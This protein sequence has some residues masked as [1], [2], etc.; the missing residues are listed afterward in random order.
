MTTAITG[1]TYPVKDE[2]KALGGRWNAERKAWMVPA[3]R[4]DEARA[5]VA[6]THTTPARKDVSYFPRRGSA[7]KTMSRRQAEW[8]REEGWAG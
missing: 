3:D 1:N 2:L 8:L 4:A 7:R 6:G 5:L